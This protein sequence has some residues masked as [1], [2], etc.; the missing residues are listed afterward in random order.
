MFDTT[1]FQLRMV[2][3][4]KCKF[5]L[6]TNSVDSIKNPRSDIIY[7]YKDNKCNNSWPMY[8][9]DKSNNKWVH[10]DDMTIEDNEI[11]NCIIINNE[12]SIVDIKDKEIKSITIPNSINGI[13]I[14]SIGYEA[15]F[16][17][18]SLTSVTIP[19][20]VTDI[21]DWAFACCESLNEII[22][23]H[24]VSYI[25]NGAFHGCDALTK[26]RYTGT[27]QLWDEII[28]GRCNRVLSDTTITYGP[29]VDEHELLPLPE[30]KLKNGR[31]SSDIIGENNYT[32]LEIPVM[33]GREH[34]KNIDDYGFANWR[35]LKTL[36]IPDSITRIGKHAFR[37]C[38]ELETITISKNLNCIDSYAFDNCPNITTINYKGSAED[39]D[40]ILICG[41]NN[42]LNSLSI[43]INY[44]YT[45]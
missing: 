37:D 11:S 25:G 28:I 13:K 27:P 20:D 43:K 45:D 34:V 29:I 1:S 23:P 2:S 38:V 31:I 26:V 41:D 6:I 21:S 40:K 33:I 10:F 18:K 15:F 42:I 36:K 24:S 16:G 39:W 4:I 17:C 12:G 9:Y 35:S 3:N 5:Q 30:Y 7:I 8:I 32:D 14:T 44:N 22:I 19:D